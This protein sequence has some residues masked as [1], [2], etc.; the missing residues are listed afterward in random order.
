MK[1]MLLLCLFLWVNTVI[2]NAYHN[3]SDSS[4]YPILEEFHQKK[5]SVIERFSFKSLFAES[6]SFSPNTRV[7][8]LG[9]GFNSDVIANSEGLKKI[10][11]P[12]SI[13]LEKAVG[14][15]IGI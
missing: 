9:S 5:R 13:L 6:E 14:K 12:V 15:N 2:S 11:P 3:Q 10:I 7:L 4:S 1:R 8:H